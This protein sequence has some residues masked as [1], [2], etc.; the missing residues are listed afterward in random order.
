MKGLHIYYYNQLLQSVLYTFLLINRPILSLLIIVDIFDT[1]LS[2][3]I[4]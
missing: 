2:T 4:L 3:P 1:I